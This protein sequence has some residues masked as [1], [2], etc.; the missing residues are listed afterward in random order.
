MNGV[1]SDAS[2]E[3]SFCGLR[4]VMIKIKFIMF[5]RIL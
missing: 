5:Y 1:D 2:A 4:N 3:D